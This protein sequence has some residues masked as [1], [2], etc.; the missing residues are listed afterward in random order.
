RPE[1]LPELPADIADRI[2]RV[3][4]PF[5]CVTQLA[6]D[7]DDVTADITPHRELNNAALT[8]LSLWVPALKL[9]K[10]RP[11][12]GGDEAVAIWRPSST[13]R[14]DQQRSRN[15]K[16]SPQGIRDFGAD[17]GYTPIDLVMIA[18]GL[19]LDAAF[20]FLSERLGWAPEISI[21][22]P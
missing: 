4:E 14:P 3:P 8:R 16:I 12:R 15:L 6:I 5:G 21:E 13:G 2:T 9:Y 18:L 20:A 10:C 1:D 22:L 19:E 7:P 17:T 11:A